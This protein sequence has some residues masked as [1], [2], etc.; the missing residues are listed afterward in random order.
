MSP[1][2]AL[3]L[4]LLALAPAGCATPLMHGLR[5]APGPW[6]EVSMGMGYTEERLTECAGADGC[7]D[8]GVGVAG[9]PLQV[10]AG[11][12][13][14]FEENIGL[15]IGAQ[16]PARSNQKLYTWWADLSLT[17]FATVQTEHLSVGV[18]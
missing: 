2:R 1:R 17:S 6:V 11:Y 4:L 16:L 18:G 8:P 14:V 15:L 12:A 3:L 13:W 9:N 10:G 7:V 5:A